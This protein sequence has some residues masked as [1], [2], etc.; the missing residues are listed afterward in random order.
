MT[1]IKSGFQKNP[2][3]REHTLQSQKPHIELLFTKELPTRKDALELESDLHVMYENK[4]L[5]GE[6]FKLTND[7]IS[8]LDNHIF[9]E[10]R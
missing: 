4:H 5:R 3:F 10:T 6:W 8:Y 2:N 9:H 1:L 7:D